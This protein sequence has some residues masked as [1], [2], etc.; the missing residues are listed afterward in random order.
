MT[1]R[2]MSD[3]AIVEIVDEVRLPLLR[4]PGAPS[5]GLS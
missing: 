1:M 5:N 4:V 3:E 2:A